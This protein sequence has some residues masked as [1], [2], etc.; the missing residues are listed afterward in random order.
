MKPKYTNTNPFH[1]RIVNITY[2]PK[3]MPM[4]KS[5]AE[6]DEWHR[7]LGRMVAYGMAH[8]VDENQVYDQLEMVDLN[9][10]DADEIVGAYCKKLPA[11]EAVDKNGWP[12]YY[13][14][15]LAKVQ[16]TL[17]TVQNKT[18]EKGRPFILGAVKSGDKYGFHS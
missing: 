8:E 6:Q 2:M 18:L 3:K 16:E 11:T 12:I 5:S 4:F 7:A 15:D 17:G 13:K 10:V 14:G 1:V 9:I